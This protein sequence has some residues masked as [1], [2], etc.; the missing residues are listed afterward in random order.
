MAEYGAMQDR[1]K[2]LREDLIRT[3]TLLP[4]TLAAIYSWAFTQDNLDPVGRIVLFWIPVPLVLIAFLRLISRYASVKNLESYL[5]LLECELAMGS[6]SPGY[7]TWLISRPIYSHHPFPKRLNWPLLRISRY[8][9]W[10]VMLGGSVYLAFW[11]TLIDQP[12][13]L[14]SQ[15]Q[16][17]VV[18]PLVGNREAK[19]SSI[20]TATVHKGDSN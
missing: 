1:L 11:A 9:L 20:S 16:K 4:L 13:A 5:Q 8:L 18:R 19:P 2:F 7:E 10:A 15:N 12:S 17:E 14:K 3:E 6:C